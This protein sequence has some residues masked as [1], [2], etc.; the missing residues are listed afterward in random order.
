[1]KVSATELP[2]LMTVANFR[3][4]D[5]RGLFVKNFNASAFREAGLDAVF[6]ESFYSVSGRNVIRGMHFQ[7][8]PAATA[9]LITVLSGRVLD[10]VFDLRRSSPTFGRSF[11][12]EL[13]GSGATLLFIPAGL[14]HGFCALEEGT[15]MFYMCTAAFAADLDSGFRFDSFGFGWPCAAV[16]ATVSARDRKLPGLDELGVIFP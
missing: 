8:P 1:M 9:K 6:A 4:A 3:A 10:V 12:I 11:A 16:A 5:E 14:A 2:G 7:R 15:A 13:D